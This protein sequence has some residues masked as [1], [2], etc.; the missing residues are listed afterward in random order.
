VR[1]VALVALCSL[2]F[3]LHARAD[4]APPPRIGLE[5]DPLQYAFHGYSVHASVV[6][7]EHARATF[8]VYGNHFS[9]SAETS[10]DVETRFALVFTLSAYLR[11]DARGFGAGVYAID[12]HRN[13]GAPQNGPTVQDETLSVGPFVTF[14]WFP[15]DALGLY[16]RPWAGLSVRVA[17]GGTRTAGT[18]T[19]DESRFGY[20][21]ALH[22]GWEIGL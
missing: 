12:A 4:D 13:L 3:A 8:G 2:A 20:V 6:P 15:F 11:A 16:A 10:W 7:F 21:L 18:Q 1:R 22:L 17:D 5:I 9:P 14:A 19:Y